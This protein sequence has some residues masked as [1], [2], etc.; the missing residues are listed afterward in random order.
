MA[1]NSAAPNAAGGTIE[2]VRPQNAEAESSG[3][4]VQ[5]YVIDDRGGHCQ[6]KLPV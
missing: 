6:G 2:L 3:L 5:F 1:L 4:Q